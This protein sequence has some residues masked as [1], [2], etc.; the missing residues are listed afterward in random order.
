M[1]EFLFYLVFFFNLIVSG[2]LL[3]DAL[4]NLLKEKR[5]NMRLRFYFEQPTLD[6]ETGEGK[7]PLAEC[8][9]ANNKKSDY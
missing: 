9:C 4:Y 6:E 1:R 5:K 3:N 7:A 8:V 2:L